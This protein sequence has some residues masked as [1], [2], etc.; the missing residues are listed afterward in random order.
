MAE[1]VDAWYGQWTDG[2]GIGQVGNAGFI[3]ISQIYKTIA[4][5]I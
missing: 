1:T 3:N 4:K 5:R 2:I